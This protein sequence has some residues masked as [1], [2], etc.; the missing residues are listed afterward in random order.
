MM[1]SILIIFFST[2]FIS[3]AFAQV[4]VSPSFPTADQEI[5]ITYDATQGTSGLAGVSKVF[6]HSGVVL[7][8]PT[9]TGWSNVKGTWGDPN[10]VG[11]M[12]KT[13]EGK[14]EIKLVPRTYF[15]VP[16]GTTIYRIGMVFRSA[17]PC[18]GFSGNTTPCKE[19][20]SP[21][22][23]DIFIDI[24]EGVQFQLSLAQPAQFPLIKNTG[25]QISIV[26]NASE[27]SDFTI[28]VN[29][30]T[31]NTKSAATSISYNH[32]ITETSGTATVTVSATNG[33][34]TKETSFTYTIRKATV[35]AQRPAGIIDGIN[36]DT[37][38]TK[39]TL[40]VWAPGKSSVY[41]FGDFTD[42]QIDDAYQMKKD[43][44][45][46]WID[47]TGL[48]A[49]KEYGF[50][51]FVDESIRI[52]D[53]YADKILDPD[54]QYIPSAIYPDLKPFPS[55][56]VSDK[57]YFNRV[58]V[59]QTA[60]TPFTW[61]ATNWQKPK[62]EKL[63]IYELL[64]RDFFGSNARSYQS[65]ID[66]LSYFKRLGINAIELMPIMEFNG[67]DSWG[68]N[69]TFMFAP[70]KYYGPKNKLKELVDAC[71]QQGIA[72]ILDIVLN[73]QDIPNPYVMLD[74]DFVNYKPTAANKWFNV[75]ATHPY[76][77]FYDM[78][79]ESKYTQAYV[80][81][82]THYWLNEYKVDGYRF[83]LSKGFTQTNHPNDVA[84]WSAYDAS[85]IHILERMADAIWKHTPDAY[86]ILE[87]L[88]EN[89]EEKELAEYR[90]GEGKGMMPWGNLNYAYNQNT[91]GFSEGSDFSSINY[92]NRNWT[93]PHLVG[94][95]ESHDEE[96]L[97]YKNLQFGNAA[98][99]YSVKNLNT[100]LSR[101]KAAAACF[102][103]IP[104]PKMLW[105][106]GELGYDQSIN[107]CG[108]G[109]INNDCR[110]AA[111]PV[112]WD[113]LNVAERKSLF[114]TVADLIHLRSEYNLFT[115][116]DA[117]IA[118]TGLIKQITIKS[119]PYKDNPVDGTE[120]N[121]QVV[122]NFGLGTESVAVTFP[123]TGIWYDY[124]TPG[125][126]VNVT[127]ATRTMN[128]SAGGFKLFTDV[129]ITGSPV[130][131]TEDESVSSF[132]VYPKPSSGKYYID[133]KEG[134][135]LRSLK[136]L[137][138][139][140]QAVPY[141]YD[142]NVLDISSQPHGLYFLRTEAEQETKIEVIK[143]VKK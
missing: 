34:E 104:G 54:D 29:G 43:G 139:L 85:R 114:E 10:S 3:A 66:T 67:N 74:F 13:P 87:H 31:V 132:S 23:G 19:G 138:A 92:V 81:T 8:G 71:H 97:M 68:Y 96:R 25:E 130:T 129:N 142:G 112:K 20:K 143:L 40:S 64:I 89:A 99:S 1:R 98:G 55:K 70:D 69:P 51:Y 57:S 118:S 36:Y 9:G 113:Y 18:G 14:W 16:N 122:A 140:G 59:F 120:M 116:G 27:T 22:N 12:T 136:V 17:G 45:H 11:E 115:S 94:Y 84:A 61:K 33:T 105:E 63:V 135:R 134:A 83:D 49:G 119:K 102:Y 76:S 124:F 6:M 47:I 109:T 108:D 77:V 131:A 24:Y 21:A 107:T 106:F 44:E 123:H 2:L 38:P 141:Q 5:T 72:V 101:M 93:V 137:N 78:N 103:T 75:T 90:S 82:I 128:V 42:W 30:A 53:P 110:V 127:S 80:D 15:G 73:H 37:D 126:T 28:K 65:V 26:A 52:A 35:S 86:V 41:A 4:T 50:Q 39:V 32:T 117:T 125:N 79:H 95:M 46:F 48:T 100:A 121:A 91:L 58:S 62:P 56:A 133:V 7:S 60:Q 111:K 88:S